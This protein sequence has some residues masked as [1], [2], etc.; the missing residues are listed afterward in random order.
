MRAGHV[1]PWYLLSMSKCFLNIPLLKVTGLVLP[2]LLVSLIVHLDS[3]NF[4]FLPLQE[5]TS[6]TRYM[7]TLAVTN[8]GELYHFLLLFFFFFY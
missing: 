2:V 3:G 8:L 6:P 1:F 7:I 4:S 5:L